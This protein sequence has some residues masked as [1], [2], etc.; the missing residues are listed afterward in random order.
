MQDRRNEVRMLCA[1]MVNVQ[2]KDKTGRT[3]KLLAHLEDI[4]LSGACLQLDMPVPLQT[5]LRITYRKGKVEGKVLGRLEGNVQ[6]C[7]YH[8]IGY[9]IGVEFGEGFRW[10]QREFKPQH[11]VDPRRLAIRILKSKK[12]DP[13]GFEPATIQ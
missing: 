8:E 12:T 2:W 4:S 9:F 3:R 11:M 6:Y 13:V 7:V 1:D 10:S 5:V